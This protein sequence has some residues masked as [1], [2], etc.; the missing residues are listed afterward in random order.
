MSHWSHFGALVAVSHAKSP[1]R[2]GLLW[3]A[4]L[5]GIDITIPE[6]PK[7]AESDLKAFNSTEGS[8]ITRGS[9]LAWMGHLTALRW[10]LSTDHQTALI[11]EDDVDF[12]LHLPSQISST[13]HALRTLLSP[14]L[15][16]TSPSTILNTDSRFWASP[17]TWDILWLGHCNDAASPAHVLS[18]P[19]ISYPDPHTP[20]LSSIAPPASDLL[21]PSICQTA[22]CYTAPTGPSAPSPTP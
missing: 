16:A 3:S 5:T 18:H 20:P 12:S 13:A 11:L 2:E 15:P 19:S 21:E 22:G 8:R 17:S 10:F 6:Q 14:G 9:A 1:R 7:W 4:K